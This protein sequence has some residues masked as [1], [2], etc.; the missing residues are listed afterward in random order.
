MPRAADLAA[1]EKAYQSAVAA[2]GPDKESTERLMA[3]GAL[4]EIQMRQG[5]VEEA[6]A[7]SAELLKAAPNNPLVKQLRGQIAAAGGDSTRRARCSK[8]PWLRCRTTPRPACCS[9]S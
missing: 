7:T 1:A 2:A 8:R 5:K 9:A 4:A 6:T 3:L